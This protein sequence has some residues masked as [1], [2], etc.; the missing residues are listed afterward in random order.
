MITILIGKSGAGKDA[1]QKKLVSDFGY[2]QLI[3]ITTR[4]MREGEV[5]GREYIFMSNPDFYL[6]MAKD[7]ILE[8]RAYIRDGKTWLYGSQKRDILKENT[9]KEKN[10]VI[11]LDVEGAKSYTAY[12]GRENCR[13]VY[14]DV[15]EHIRKV[16]AMDRGSFDPIEWE[17]RAKD[18]NYRFADEKIRGFVDEYVSNLGSIEETAKIINDSRYT[19]G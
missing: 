15:P 3:N 6:L 9:A 5:N 1:L 19:N 2:E 10:Y 4:P 8:H 13:V 12:Y 11:I 16:R 18:D 17:K 7:Q 14:V